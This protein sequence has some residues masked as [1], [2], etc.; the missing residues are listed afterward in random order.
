M[1][2]FVLK[3]TVDYIKLKT[4]IIEFYE[5]QLAA[6]HQHPS[7]SVN[8]SHTTASLMCQVTQQTEKITSVLN[9]IQKQQ[10][11]LKQNDFFL[12]RT[13]SPKQL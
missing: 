4:I 3:V 1:K 13:G 2:D 6:S 11:I 7:S 10:T 5:Q 8:A 12:F 9:L